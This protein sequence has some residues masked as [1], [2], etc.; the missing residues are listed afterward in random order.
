M[1]Y[2]GFD[3]RA[4]THAAVGD[5]SENVLHG[6]GSEFGI[7]HLERRAASESA[8]RPPEPASCGI[9]VAEVMLR[10]GN[11]ACEPVEAVR[12]VPGQ[13]ALVPPPLEAPRRE[14]EAGRELF[15]CEA[16]GMHHLFDDGLRK[17]LP[18]RVLEIRFRS[19]RSA[20]NRLATQFFNHSVEFG[21]HSCFTIL[22]PSIA[23]NG[24]NR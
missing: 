19:E 6:P 9:I 22:S 10:Q 17:A 3:R 5:A 13:S 21:Y 2:E 7:D 18:N 20:E 12:F 4:S 23:P 16:G 14:I 24:A 11:D 1:V 8:I 15:Q